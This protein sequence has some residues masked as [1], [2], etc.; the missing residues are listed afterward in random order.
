MKV[1]RKDIHSLY[2]VSR[3][4]LLEI[5]VCCSTVSASP[6]ASFSAVLL[7]LSIFLLIRLILRW[8]SKTYVLSAGGDVG[9]GGFVDS[10]FALLGVDFLDCLERDDFAAF[11][12][13][14][15]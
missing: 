10:F 14:V 1:S 5:C 6:W 8:T 3:S 4:G 13:R 11:F 7:A 12:R 2:C 9:G 15:F